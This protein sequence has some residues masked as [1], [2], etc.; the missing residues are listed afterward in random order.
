MS[1]LISQDIKKWNSE[2]H[3]VVSDRESYVI[4]AE[5][6]TMLPEMIPQMLPESS[7]GFPAMVPGSVIQHM[8]VEQRNSVTTVKGKRKVVLV[9]N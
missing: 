5:V 4:Y 7:E 2:M 6:N 1:I 9:L 3:R 8:K